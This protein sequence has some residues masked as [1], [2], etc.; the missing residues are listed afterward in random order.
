[1]LNLL[2]KNWQLSFKICLLVLG[3]AANL[4]I[5]FAQTPSKDTSISS[6]AAR[7]GY[8]SFNVSKYLTVGTDPKSNIGTQ[9]QSYLKSSNP[10]ASFILQIINFLSL[11]VASVSFLGIV[12]GGFLL[13]ASSGNENMVNKGKEVI[14][15]A[16]IGLVLTL[17][18]YFIVS[19]VQNLLFETAGK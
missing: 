10:I 18:S 5:S 14:T 8:A 4:S 19:F 1:M 16:V 3:L 6:E 13:L 11:T 15:Y 2:K 9:E 7:K 17:S 12:V